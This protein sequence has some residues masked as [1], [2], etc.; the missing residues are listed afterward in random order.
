MESCLNNEIPERIICAAIWF[1]DGIKRELMPKNIDKGI[2]VCGWRHGNCNI[3]LNAIFPKRDYLI[4][5][6]DGK[7]TIQ[8]FLTSDNRFLNRYDAGKI[9]FEAGQTSK[10]IDYLFSEDIY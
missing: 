8:G 9:A 6:K 7:T 4:K 2:V 1:K 10:L 3:I 5:N